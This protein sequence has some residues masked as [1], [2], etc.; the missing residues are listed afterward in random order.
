MKYLLIIFVITFQIVFA[1][2]ETKETR[3]TVSKTKGD[4][5]ETQS[6]AIATSEDITPR[7]NLIVIN[8]L[9][10]F[11]FY[12]LSYFHKFEEGT[13]VGIG[14]QIPTLPGIDGFGINAEVRIYPHGKNLRGFYL[15]PNLS[16]NHLTSGGAST[17]PFSLGILIGWQWFPGEEFAIGLGIGV[18][19]YWGS[20]SDSRNDF[21]KYNG[22]VPA[23]RF[24]IGYG[25]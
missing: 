8:P 4:T 1:Q 11:L 16:Y 7:S 9:K 20:I 6:V 15:A 21:G 22:Y 5:T 3:K 14:F 17:D 12:N 25:W 2:T 23:V 24:D 18:D 19:H 13:A 10:F